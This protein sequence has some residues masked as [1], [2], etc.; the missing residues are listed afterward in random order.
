M[1][2]FNSRLDQSEKRIIEFQGKSPELE[3]DSGP[4]GSLQTTW[5]KCVQAR[6][7][8]QRQRLGHGCGREAWAFASLWF[9][10][11]W[12][13]VSAGAAT[14]EVSAPAHLPPLLQPELGVSR[15]PR[16]LERGSAAQEWEFSSPGYG[17]SSSTR[18]TKLLLGWIMQGKVSSFTSFL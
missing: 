16:W 8:P 14:A 2:N 15:S 4:R 11:S 7:V 1:E 3:E 6:R 9:L 17:D 5:R 13:A 18:S 10:G 12:P